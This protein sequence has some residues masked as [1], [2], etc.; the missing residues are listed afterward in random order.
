MNWLVIIVKLLPFIFQMVTLAEKAFSDKPK[1]GADKKALVTTG[2]KAAVGA[3]TAISTG[4]QADTWNRIA[5][6]VSGIIDMA[7][8]IMYPRAELDDINF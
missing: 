5:E 7:A 4:G 8:G 1:S 2:A 3:I 6:P